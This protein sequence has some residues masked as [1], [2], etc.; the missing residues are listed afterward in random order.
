MLA[1]DSKN[2]LGLL[3]RLI[4]LGQPGEYAKALIFLRL[5]CLEHY[6]GV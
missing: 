3:G 6:Q 2:L 4:G 5:L 1:E